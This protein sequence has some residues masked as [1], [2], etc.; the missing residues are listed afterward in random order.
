MGNS[1]SAILFYGYCWSDEDDDREI[2]RSIRWYVRGAPASDSSDEDDDP[3][4]PTPEWPAAIAIHR[5]HKNPWDDFT[6]STH[7]DYAQRNAHDKAWIAA[8]RAELDAWH[9]A[10]KAVEAEFGVE[11]SDHGSPADDYSAPHLL[12]K[13]TETRTESLDGAEITAEK[14]VADPEWRTRLDA[15]FSELGINPPQK[16]PRWWLVVHYG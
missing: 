4:T 6:S 16:E 9:A 1:A 3:E 15:W 13:E 2:K 11:M 7:R 5:G 10:Q 14:M 12:I 8:H